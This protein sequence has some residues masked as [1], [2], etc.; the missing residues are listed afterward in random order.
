[1]L[2]LLYV[3]TN[4]LIHIL[5]IFYIDILINLYLITYYIILYY[6]II[7]FIMLYYIIFFI[8][9]FVF[10]FF[11]ELVQSTY[12]ILLYPFL[13]FWQ[14]MLVIIILFTR[15]L[16]QLTTSVSSTFLHCSKLDVLS[17]L[18]S[19]FQNI[20]RVC[21]LVFSSIV[22]KHS[23]HRYTG[24]SA[25]SRWVG[26]R[27]RSSESVDQSILSL[28]EETRSALSFTSAMSCA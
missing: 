4:S 1:M 9:I 23:W 14:S 17:D 12:F 20:S 5:I 11:L 6:Y 7:N 2:L 26:G 18:L 15:A 19:H 25:M 10:F 8:C 22:Q 3:Y 27:A 16:F 21:V 13:S 24:T 28:C